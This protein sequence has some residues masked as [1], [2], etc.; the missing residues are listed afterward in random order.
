[1]KLSAILLLTLLSGAHATGLGSLRGEEPELN[2]GLICTLKG[3]T[4]QS[5]CDATNSEDGSTCV[6]CSYSTYGVCVSGDIAAQME[7]TIPGIEC[8]DSP[9]DDDNDMDDDDAPNDDI[10]SDDQVQDDDT[11]PSDDSVPDDYWD[12]LKKYSTADECTAAGCGWCDNK[13][14]YGVCFDVEV[15]K[16][17]DDSDW[18]SCTIP[19]TTTT[20]SSTKKSL[21]EQLK[22]PSDPSCVIATIGGD[23]STCTATTDAE[24]KHCDWCSFQ[25]FDFCL[26][27]DQA[28]LA[29]Q[30]GASCAAGETAMVVETLET[31]HSLSDPSD[32]T[33]LVVTIG[34]DESTC[35]GT[36]DVD[37][38]PCD[39]CSFMGYDFCVNVDQAQIVEQY[40]A[41]CGDRFQEIVVVEEKEEEKEQVQDPSDPSCIIA[42]L[43]GDESSCKSTKDSEGNACEWCSLP[44]NYNFCLNNDQVQVV[45]QLGVTCGD[46]IVKEEEEEEQDQ[47]SDPSDPTCLVATLG[48]DESSCKA[49]VDVDGKACEWCSLAGYDFCLNDDQAEI[50]EQYGAAC[51]SSSE[52]NAS[53]S[54]QV[55]DPSDPTCL[56][57]TLGGDESSCKATMDAEGKACEWCSLQ[58][59]DFCL[60][61][62]QAEIVEQYG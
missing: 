42:T 55:Q 56:V 50:V 46:N 47:V 60:D 41:D 31:T 36:E 45:E 12:C 20:T 57:A 39:W 3:G 7:Q 48:G 2:A 51:S 54:N 29:Q 21:S 14:G 19:T 40:G 28:E 58:G 16:G 30:Y 37:G 62:D 17:F 23:A 6:W 15:A 49:T 24:G 32:P 13:G 5:S 25:G 26:N 10:D 53:S 8:D 11:Q 38:K 35:K 44:P 4:S 1:M 52:I 34:G 9:S 59:Y 18:Y 61:E 22:D 27:A 33:C 43:G